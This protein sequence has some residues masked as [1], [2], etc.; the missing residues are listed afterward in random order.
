MFTGWMKAW[1]RLATFLLSQ[2]CFI[3]LTGV[4]LLEGHLIGFIVLD[5]LSFVGVPEVLG[6]G[7]FRC[8][9]AEKQALSRSPRSS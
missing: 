5:F 8:D 7:V 9:S 6:V 1:Q 4:C 3:G 2:W